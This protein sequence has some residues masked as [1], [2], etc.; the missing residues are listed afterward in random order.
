MGKCGSRS[1]FSAKSLLSKVGIDLVE[2]NRF[3]DTYISGEL[4]RIMFF[5]VQSWFKQVIVSCPRC[6]CKQTARYMNPASLQIA[7]LMFDIFACWHSHGRKDIPA[8]V[9]FQPN[10]DVERVKHQRP[11]GLLVCCW[12]PQRV[13]RYLAPTLAVN[14]ANMQGL[15][16]VLL[17]HSIS[18]FFPKQCDHPRD[19]YRKC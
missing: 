7:A 18:M 15:T 19:S 14:E 2:L 4:A 3:W 11:A 6:P 1:K 17:F 8:K 10:V 13:K 5:A 12:G 16:V 9:N